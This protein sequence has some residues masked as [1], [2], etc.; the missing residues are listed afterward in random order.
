MGCTVGN[1][2]VNHLMFADDTR[3]APALVDF[4]VFWIFV[5]MMM[6]NTKSLLIATKQLVYLF[7]PRGITNLL[8]RIFFQMG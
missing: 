4:I 7:A 5:M 3:V 6:L 2:I 1:M 8:H